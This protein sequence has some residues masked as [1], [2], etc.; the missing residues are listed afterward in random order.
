MI[1]S[2]AI[3]SKAFWKMATL[4]AQQFLYKLYAVIQNRFDV[5][6]YPIVIGKDSKQFRMTP[7][8]IR[9]AQVIQ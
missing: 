7:R 1:V 8:A 3:G 9:L 4:Q 5:T 2:S 6:V